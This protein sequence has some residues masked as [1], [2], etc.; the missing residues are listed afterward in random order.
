MRSSY[1][2]AFRVTCSLRG[3][4]YTQIVWGTADAPW[5]APCFGQL[6][7]DTVAEFSSGKWKHKIPM[8]GRQFLWTTPTGPQGSLTMVAAESTVSLCGRSMATFGMI[9][10]VTTGAAL[11]AKCMINGN[12]RRSTVSLTMPGDAVCALYLSCI[13][14]VSIFSLVSNRLDQGTSSPETRN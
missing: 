13:N 10:R 14:C 4:V 8:A 11:S 7:S 9:C 1:Y 12:R 3:L 6:D 5:Q 2:I